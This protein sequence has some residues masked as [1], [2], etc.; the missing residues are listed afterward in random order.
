MAE[1]SDQLQ[2]ILKDQ[3][4]SDNQAKALLDAF[5]APFTE[6][7]EILADYQTI[8]VTDESQ[9]AL[10]KQAREKRLKLKEI[11]V[12]VEHKRQE[13][14]ADINKTGKAIDDVARFVKQIIEPAEAHLLTQEKFAEV[15]AKERAAQLK[16]D[17]IEKL[18][19]YTSNLS[20]YDLDTMTEA[21]F[22]QLLN[23]LKAA[24]E[25]KVAEAKRQEEAEAR[26][27]TR[28]SKISELGMRWDGTKYVV[29]G[30]EL[31][32]TMDDIAGMSDDSFTDRCKKV[33]KE[34]EARAAEQE[35]I[36]QENIK[37][38]AEADKKAAEAKRVDDLIKQIHAP[39]SNLIQ[40]PPTIEAVD[41]AIKKLQ[42]TVKSLS[43]DD[44][45]ITRVMDAVDAATESL[46]NR[47]QRIIADQ[48][49]AKLEK[50]KADQAAAEAKAK[51]DKEEEERQAL[52]APDKEK[53]LKFSS[54]LEMIRTEK[55]PAVKTKQAQDIV[56]AIDTSL[57]ALHKLIATKA[58]QL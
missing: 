14:K 36:R 28:V 33:T 24:H 26:K 57:A 52:L 56:N 58:K 17:R 25:S 44:A 23:D 34:L 47:K 45:K 42:A 16:A 39:Y 30:S 40:L 46:N 21:T 8:E 54:A 27:R 20:I 37:L 2:V 13:L 41:E 55:L 43:E 18:S 15:K 32:F 12:G 6:A 49:A 22:E 31:E 19:A 4:V 29:P 5:G 1:Q 7:G 38:K 10:M 9:T 51:A 35:R 48:K 11:R 53:L 50:E 3:G